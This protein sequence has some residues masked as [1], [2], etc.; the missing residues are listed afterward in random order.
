MLRVGAGP[1]RPLG[2]AGRERPSRG[3]HPRGLSGYDRN[4]AVW[5]QQE[6]QEEEDGGT[7]LKGGQLMS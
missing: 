2:L 4:Q 3:S 6:S 1:E 5:P 7:V